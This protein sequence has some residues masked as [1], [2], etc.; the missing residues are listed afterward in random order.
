MSGYETV[1]VSPSIDDLGLV[2]Q[3][4]LVIHNDNKSFA[5]SI[6]SLSTV[7]KQFALP[8]VTRKSRI[9]STFTK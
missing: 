1:P 8:R 4:L 3:A 5:C 2:R 6:I 9:I 7:F